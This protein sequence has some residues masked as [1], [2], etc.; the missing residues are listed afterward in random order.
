MGTVAAPSAGPTSCGSV[1]VV[2]TAADQCG[3]SARST[4]RFTVQDSAAPVFI[5]LPTDSTVE[6]DGSGNTAARTAWLSSNAGASA[7][8]NCAATVPIVSRQ[9]TVDG[10]ACAR[11]TSYV[12]TASDACG[13][14]VNATARFIITDLTAPTFTTEPSDA[15]Y[16]CDGRGNEAQIASYLS[17][18]GG[19]RVRDACTTNV[20]LTND[21]NSQRLLTCTSAAVTFRAC[22]SCGNATLVLLLLLLRIP[23]P[24]CSL[25]SLKITSFLAMLIFLRLFW[26]LPLLSISALAMSPSTWL[27]PLNKSP[28]TVTA[29]VTLSLPVPTLLWMLVVDPSP[30]PKLLLF[31]VNVDL[32][33]VLL[34]DASVMAAVLLPLLLTVSLWTARLFLVAVLLAR[35]SSAVARTPRKP[36]ILPPNVIW[37][38][39]SASPSTSTSTTMMMTLLRSMLLNA[40]WSATNL[41]IFCK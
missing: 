4:G 16:E 39:L 13:N 31:W 1:N 7:S 29:L 22:D 8:D 35:L 26:V 20:T 5:N 36:L 18:N 25:L 11:A 28:P 17:N 30:V 10:T 14:S 41:S 2:V 32:V 33:L 15:T 24:L 27:R 23:L 12:F 34:R 38:F 6:C 9:L 19:A 40:P 3:N 37:N 21:F